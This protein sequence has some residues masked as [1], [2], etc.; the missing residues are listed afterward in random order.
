MRCPS[1]L[2]GLSHVS[3]AEPGLG[4]ASQLPRAFSPGQQGAKAGTTPLL[5]DITKNELGAGVLPSGKFGANAAWFRLALL[6]H[7]VL[8]AMKRLVLPPDLKDARSLRLRF[9]VFAIAARVVHHARAIA[10]RIAA[11][12]LEVVDVIAGRRR[13]AELVLT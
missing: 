1:P 4:T 11:R 9:R 3:P 10:A 7:N 6:T 2:R 8:V 12:V 5:H 13:V